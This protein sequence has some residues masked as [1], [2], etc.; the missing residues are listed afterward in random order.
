MGQGLV[1]PKTGELDSEHSCLNS[2]REMTT[3]SKWKQIHVK[4]EG[5]TSPEY[6]SKLHVITDGAPHEMGS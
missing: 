3:R 1:D 4:G 5:C 6:R 2:K